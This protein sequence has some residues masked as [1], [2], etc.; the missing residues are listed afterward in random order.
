MVNLE[1]HIKVPMN[2]NHFH[3]FKNAR[4]AILDWLSVHLFLHF[5]FDGVTM[6]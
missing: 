2:I 6:G 1:N 5:S 4:N 3:H